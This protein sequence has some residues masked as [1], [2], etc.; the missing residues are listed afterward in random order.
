MQTKIR[1]RSISEG[2]GKRSRRTAPLQ[3]IYAMSGVWYIS[4]IA[5]AGKDREYRMRQ[6]TKQYIAGLFL[7]LLV[8]SIAAGGIMGILYRSYQREM[9]RAAMLLGS[10]GMDWDVFRVLKGEEGISKNDAKEILADHGYTNPRSS[11][12]GRQFL[13]DCRTVVLGGLVLWLGTVGLLGFGQYRKKKEEDRLSRDIVEQ[14]EKIREG[15]YMQIRPE[16]D[17]E[18]PNRKR[19]LD[20]LDSL[21]SYVEMIRMQAHQEK[22]ET[23]TLVTDLSH[24]LKTP[25]AAL[26]SCYDIL[27]T[28][29]LSQEERREFRTRME[30]QLNSLEQLISA[31]VN[32]SRMETGMIRLQPEKGRKRGSK[33]QR[34]HL[35]KARRV[36]S[37]VTDQ[38]HRLGMCVSH[39]NAW[40][41]SRLAFDGSGRVLRG[42]QSEK[43]G[44]SYSVC[45]FQN[46]KVYNCDLNASYNIGARYFIRTLLKSLPATERLALEAKVPSCAKRSTCTLSTLVSL[47][48]VLAA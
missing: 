12:A 27:K 30:Q 32:I 9:E 28:P 8:I 13:R 17:L 2:S 5:T 48:A 19:I 14:L 21:G 10:E 37:I 26:K 16:G 36:Q 22:E 3:S 24:Q 7:S 46:G 31:L 4:G 47:Y 45:E 35:W 1:W 34:L 25:V 23:K 29:D 6:M 44:G 15:E 33:K 43:T 38:A 39:V 40:N 42:R 11:A 20:E 41:T 18:D